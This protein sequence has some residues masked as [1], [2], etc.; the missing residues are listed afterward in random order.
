MKRSV[1]FLALCFGSIQC[2]FSQTT[3]TA[4]H[5]QDN[6]VHLYFII[7]AGDKINAYFNDKP[8]SLETVSEFNEYVQR[9]IKSLKDSWVV[10][11]G[12][13]KNG[14]FDDVIK[15]LNKYRFK[16]VVKNIRND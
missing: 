1:I 14:T 13:P 7:S 8:L 4:K 2:C 6:T 10:V 3:D 5:V 11:S 15:T 16:H 9:N 12:K